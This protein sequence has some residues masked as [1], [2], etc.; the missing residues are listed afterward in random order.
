MVGIPK[1]FRQ[2]ASAFCTLSYLQAMFFY[3]NYFLPHIFIAIIAE[4]V[5]TENIGQLLFC[6]CSDLGPIRR[7]DW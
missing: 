2:R 6:R 7:L 4:A 3:Q 1:N 5:L